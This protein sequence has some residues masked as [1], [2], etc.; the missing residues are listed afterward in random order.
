MDLDALLLRDGL[1]ATTR[2]L[3]IAKV[4]IW[5]AAWPRFVETLGRA[6]ALGCPRAAMEETLL[7]ATLFYGFPRIVSAFEQLANTWPADAPPG[8]GGLPAAQQ[9]A[10]GRALFAAIYGRNEAAVRALL[11]SFHGEFHDFVLE[12]AYGRILT[13]PGLP[14]ALR[15]LLAVGALAIMDQP[16]QLLAHARGA[17][18]FGASR[19]QVR[20]VMVT[21]VGD[22][23]TVGALLER[24]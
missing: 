18:A 4:A 22:S 16:P 14:P 13:R 11:A 12:S 3:V 19:A 23:P 24:L 8:G 7:Q 2:C 6:R 21:A 9:A 20:E 5:P 10:A 15:E 1:D 17:L